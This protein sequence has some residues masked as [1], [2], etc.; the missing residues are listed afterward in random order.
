[1]LK[2]V[3]QILIFAA[4]CL[5]AA[6]WQFAFISSLPGVFNQINLGL[7]LLIFI[8]FFFG[9]RAA[10]FFIFSFGFLMDTFSFQF[11]SF[12]FIC[13]AVAAVASYLILENWLTNKSLYSFWVLFLVAT[14]VYN[15]AAGILTFLAANFQGLP[16]FLTFS[17]WR[18]VFYQSA[19]NILA[20]ALFFNISVVLAKRFQPFFLEKKSGL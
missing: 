14:L 2:K 10:L 15:L 5:V 9:A 6:T 17:F 8:L 12:Y 11:F 1:M 13:L 19:W 7:M 3:G 20:A 16:G 18:N 4:V